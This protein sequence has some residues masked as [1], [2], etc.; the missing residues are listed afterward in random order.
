MLSM[1]LALVIGRKDP[2]A[3]LTCQLKLSK[4]E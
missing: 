1:W 3:D 4:V 2:V